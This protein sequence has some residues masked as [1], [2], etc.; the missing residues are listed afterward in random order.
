MSE[1][2]FIIHSQFDATADERKEAIEM[3]EISAP[4]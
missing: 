4:D 1:I 3:I 2:Y